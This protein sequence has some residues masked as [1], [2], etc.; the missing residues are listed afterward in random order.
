MIT[1]KLGREV[2]P[3]DVVLGRA[4]QHRT[5]TGVVGSRTNQFGAQQVILRMAHGGT[6]ILGADLSYEVLI[7]EQS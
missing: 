6:M 4:R 7:Q 5:V 1:T 2:G 3:G